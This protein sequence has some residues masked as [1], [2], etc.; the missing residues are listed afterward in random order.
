M[1]YLGE[2]SNN[3]RLGFGTLKWSDGN[4]YMGKDGSDTKQDYGIFKWRDNRTY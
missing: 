3:R 4:M 1:E 2:F